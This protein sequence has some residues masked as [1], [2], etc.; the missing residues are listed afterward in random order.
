MMKLKSIADDIREAHNR[1][2][3]SYGLK[4]VDGSLDE[5]SYDAWNLKHNVV[6]PL[7]RI[8]DTYLRNAFVVDG[9]CGNGQIAE[10]LI[11]SG[12]GT[13]IGMDFS[14][15]MLRQAARRCRQ[16]GIASNIHFLCAN[17]DNL[18]SIRDAVFDGGIMFGVIEHLDDPAA[19]VSNLLRIIKPGGIFVLGIPRKGSLSHISYGLFGESPRRWGG[20]TR[21][22]DRL[23]IRE[24]LRYYRFFS[25]R[26]VHRVLESCPGHHIVERIPFAHAHVDGWPGIFLRWLGRKGQRGHSILDMINGCCRRLGF[27]P[28]GEYWIIRK[29]MK[30]V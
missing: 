4:Q 30:N 19:A 3:D 21:W 23:R 28:A 10:V 24:K 13:V 14:E 26:N 1:V 5:N 29:E 27:I 22:W 16:A 9:G 6:G 15:A 18:D 8:V 7:S 11:R 12:S 17:L 20:K 25:L 2:A